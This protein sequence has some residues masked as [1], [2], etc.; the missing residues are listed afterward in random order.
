MKAIFAGTFDPFTSGH[1]NIVEQALEVFG[2][3][4]VAV[5]N[6]V[7][8]KSAADIAL[9]VNI[10]KLAV[11]DFSNVTV[12]RFDGLLTDY[13]GKTGG[14]IIRGVRTSAD[15]EYERAHARI[16]Y[17]L[18]RVRSVFFIPAAEYE[19]VSSTVVRQLARLKADLNG[20]VARGTEKIIADH[21]GIKSL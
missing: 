6:D 10:A 1:R 11:A 20:Y 19:H 5:A 8:D 16:Y 3:V 15:L 12:E 13:V 9:R 18:G 4:T 21:Y 7:G 14:V 2:A 17:S